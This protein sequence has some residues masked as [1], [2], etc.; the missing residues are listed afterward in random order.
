M[1]NAQDN[2]KAAAAK[3]AVTDFLAYKDYLQA[4]YKATKKHLGHYSYLQ[5]AEDLG[6]SRTN[7]I[8]LIATGKRKL[9]NK[10]SQRLVE[11]LGLSGIQRRYFETLVNYQNAQKLA[12]REALFAQL[13]HIKSKTL[14]SGL[15]EAQLEFFQDWYCPIILEMMR[16]PDF[17]SD[18]HWLA[19][20]LRPRIR[21]E[22]ARRALD[23]LERLGLA[24]FDA[25][26][27]RHVPSSE[28]FTTGDE[29]ASI[30]VV[31]YHQKMIEL[32]RE[33]ITSFE[34]F[35]RDVS[36]VTI[37]VS[38]ASAARIKSEIQSFRKKIM[39]IADEDADGDRVRQ[40]NIQFFPVTVRKK[41]GTL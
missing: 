13:V 4:V 33:S 2:L 31:R 18:A 10:A 9:T 29:I 30:A 26:K 41:G 28:Q 11:A 22:Q 35:E 32:G 14:K 36:S 21:P 16:L 39:A 7:V 38:E 3:I 20:Q 40:L 19:E 5:F 8:H 1:S 37:S 24:R 34:E 23:L 25:S 12:D 27:R 6:F 15:T 17:C